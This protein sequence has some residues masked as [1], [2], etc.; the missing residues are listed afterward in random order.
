MR[1]NVIQQEARGY[2]SKVKSYLIGIFWGLVVGVLFLFLSAC[3]LVFSS[4]SQNT[5]QVFVYI[6]CGLGSLCCGFASVRKIHKKGLL[7]GLF[8][9]IIYFI[10]LYGIGFLSCGKIPLQANV[11]IQLVISL[12][13]GSLGGISAV[14]D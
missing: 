2:Q 10:V 8:A 7:H 13:C 6:S 3:I 11:M 5:A 9:G 1:T 4:I 12:L 14:N